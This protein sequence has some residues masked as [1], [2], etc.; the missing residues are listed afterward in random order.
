M[1]LGFRNTPGTST[2][3]MDGDTVGA[4]LNSADLPGSPVGQKM[5][6]TPQFVF[7]PGTEPAPFTNAGSSLHASMDLQ[8]PMA[9]GDSTYVVADFLL[10]G[11]NG[12]RISY[13]IKIFANGSPHQLMGG[14]YDSASNSYML[15]SPL[16]ANQPF[17]TQ[18]AGSASAT[19]VPWTGWQHF[20]WSISPSQFVAGLNY[21]ATEF[22]GTVQSTDPTLYEL[23][24]VHLNA[25]FHFQ[26]APAEL[27]WSMR[28]WQ[29]WT[30]G[31]SG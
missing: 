9:V 15:N 24:E 8:I 2:A 6:I 12:V 30:A 14:G 22:P 21:L 4:Y 5:M 25:E 19:G 29:V 20:E 1:Q 27:S 11:P 10:V 7:A 13:G 17:V 16:E 28:R 26:P 31:P 23:A 3:Q 18:V